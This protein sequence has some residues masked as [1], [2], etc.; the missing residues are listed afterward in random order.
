MMV[1]YTICLG[2]A[3]RL[4]GSLAALVG[5]RSDAE[6]HFQAALDLAERGGSPVWRAHV[7]H[8]WA[9]ALG[10][11]PDLEAAAQATAAALGM[12]ALAEQCPPRPAPGSA[13][14]AAAPGLPDGLSAR[15]VEV[16]RL[17][18]AGLSNREIGERLF[19]SHNTAANHIRSILQKTGSANRAEATAY[20]AHHGL[21][22]PARLGGGATG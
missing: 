13:A 7:Q 5:R 12:R 3:E 10:D 4:M 11:R 20:A 14:E 22:G 6:A 17:I 2:P 19:I 15:E 16:L 18:G 1:G 9:A 8:D 21:L